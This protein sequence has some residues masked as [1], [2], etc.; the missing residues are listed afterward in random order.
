M[1]FST[2][3]YTLPNSG[4]RLTVRF[5]RTCLE[6]FIERQLNTDLL[7]SL[8]EYIFKFIYRLPNDT[9]GQVHGRLTKHARPFNQ[10]LFKAGNMARK[11]NTGNRHIY[12]YTEHLKTQYNM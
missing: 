3:I 10:S 5:F 6:R 8:N 12:K 11:T 1:Q 2:V 7:T 9:G 4:A